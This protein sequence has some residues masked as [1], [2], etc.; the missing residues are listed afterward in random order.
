M[1]DEDDEVLFLA[2]GADDVGPPRAL[3]EA[4][5]DAYE[6]AA[7]RLLRCCLDDLPLTLFSLEEEVEVWADSES[8]P[9]DDEEEEPP[10]LLLSPLFD[11]DDRGMAT[12]ASLRILLIL[13]PVFILSMV[14]AVVVISVVG[15]SDRHFSFSGF[16]QQRQ[17]TY[18]RSL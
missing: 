2:L 5:A 10:P 8:L 12:A 11:D 9:L 17:L 14:L 18:V 1:A 6:P 16:F 7:R 4:V 13:L 3:E 15:S